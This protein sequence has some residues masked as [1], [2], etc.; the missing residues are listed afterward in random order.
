MITLISDMGVTA[1]STCLEHDRDECL[2]AL[3]EFNDFME[4]V[5]LGR[6]YECA[7]NEKGEK[8]YEG[9]K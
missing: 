3:K 4:D 2:E 8:F 9:S 1:I 7:V 5:G 6:P